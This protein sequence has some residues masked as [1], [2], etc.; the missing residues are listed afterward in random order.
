VFEQRDLAI[1]GPPANLTSANQRRWIAVQQ[2]Q[3]N[4]DALR[5]VLLGT[6]DVLVGSPLLG[7][8]VAFVAINAFEKADLLGGTEGNILKGLVVTGPF[9][10]AIG[11]VGSAVGSV[12]GAVGSLRGLV[13]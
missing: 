6:R 9:V 4:Q 12:A 7:A 3:V 5:T 1:P 8:V 11:R 10:D 2:S 13:P